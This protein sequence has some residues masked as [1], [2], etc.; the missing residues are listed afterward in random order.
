MIGSLGYT[1]VYIYILYRVPYIYMYICIYIAV[2]W[3]SSHPF[4]PFLGYDI[5]DLLQPESNGILRSDAIG[6]GGGGL[7]RLRAAG[8]V[9]ASD[10]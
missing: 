1:Y 3:D 7:L 9:A 10:T 2:Y 4:H 8:A 6:Q 5:N